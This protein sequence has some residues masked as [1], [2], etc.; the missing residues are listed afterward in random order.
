MIRC[1][2]LGRHN[3][4]VMTQ[5]QLNYHYFN[6]DDDDDDNDN[7]GDANKCQM[8]SFISHFQYQTDT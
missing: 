5:R 1:R 6:D 2:H 7:D 4:F 3:C 8:E